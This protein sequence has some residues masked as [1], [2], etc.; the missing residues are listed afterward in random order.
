MTTALG[1]IFGAAAVAGKAP[2]PGDAW[3]YWTNAPGTYA[4]NVYVYPPVLSQLIEPLR[5]VDAWQVYVVG[6][7]ALCFASLGY[8]LGRW[9]FLAVVLVIPDY[10][11]GWGDQWWAAPIESVLMGNV[12]LPLVAAIV[13]GMRHPA[14]WAVPILTKLT[15]GVGVLWFA[16]RG[17]WR[18][19]GIALGATVAVVAG[20]F[21][22]APDA[23]TGYGRFVLDNTGTTVNGPPLWGPPL[24]LRLPVAVLLLAWGARTDRM[25]VVPV[26]CSLAVVGL[27]GYATIAAVACGAFALRR[28]VYVPLIPSR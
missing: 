1:V 26:A 18:A 4:A 5:W 10:I 23:W 7:M 20:S 27:Y 8:V 22:L 24:A 15:V 25:W 2:L 28:Q 21:L 16:F 19:F 12:T 13:L 17:E 11:I 9:A 3:V 14:I 6:W